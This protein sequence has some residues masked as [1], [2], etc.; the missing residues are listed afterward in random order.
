MLRSPKLLGLLLVAP[1]FLLILPRSLADLPWQQQL[2][3]LGFRLAFVA[4]IALSLARIAR[5]ER[6]E[7]VCT[8]FLV[9]V[10]DSVTGEAVDDA[11]RAS[12]HTPAKKRDDIARVGVF[13]R[14]EARDGDEAASASSLARAGRRDNPLR[15]RNQRAT[16]CNR[17]RAILRA[18][19]AAVVS[20]PSQTTR[21]GSRKRTAP[22]NSA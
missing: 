21:S 14:R 2:L 20:M 16:A 19:C 11:T 18:T 1:L 15:R 12:M 22:K 10:S 5:T 6:T 7:K 8:I 3:S 4:T 9:D 17:V 13:A